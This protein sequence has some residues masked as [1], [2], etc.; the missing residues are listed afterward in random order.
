MSGFI[1]ALNI[2]YEER[3]TRSFIKLNLLAIALTVGLIIGGLFV[4]SL[5]ALLPAVVGFIG[6]GSRP[7]GCCSSCNGPC[8]C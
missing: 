2:A 4:I 7:S 5:V 1:S 8:C 3:E 6:L